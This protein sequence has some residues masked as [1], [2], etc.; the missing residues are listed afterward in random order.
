MQREGWQPESPP[1]RLDMLA[2]L[3]WRRGH[4]VAT[5]V[6]P[7]NAILAEVDGEIYPFDFILSDG[8][9]P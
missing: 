1:T 7:E 4:V 3:T 9:P 2:T 8:M 5:D 6:R